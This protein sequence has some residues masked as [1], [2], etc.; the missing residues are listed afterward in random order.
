MRDFK[1]L[2]NGNLVDGAKTLDVINPATEEVFSSAPR[3]DRAQLEEAVSAAKNAFPSWSRST[4][5]E[6]GTLLLQLADVIEKHKDEFVKTLTLEQ[7]KTL[8]ESAFEFSLALQHLRYVASLD[9]PVKIIKEDRNQK[10]I[11]KNSPLGVIAIITAWNIPLYLLVIKSAPALL[12]GNT[13]VIKPAPSTPLTSLKFS[14]LCAD[15]FPAGVV[16]TVVDNN[17]LG[18]LLTS[19]PDVAK[20]SFT[21]S[22]ETGKKIMKSV[23]GTLKR[24]TLEL[25]GNDAAIVLNDVDPKEIAPKIF[26]N[27][28]IFSG[29]GC[30]AI[31]RVYVHQSQ[32][33]E[34]CHELGM[35]A[36]NVVVGDGTKAGTEMGP[37]QNKAQFDR[38]KTF[39]EDA[40]RDGN[41]V[42]G[43]NTPHPKGYFIQPTIVRDIDDTSRLV[44][45][46][47]FGPILPVL[48]YTEIDDAIERINNSPYGLGGSVWSKNIDH[49][50]EVASRINSGTVW[51]NKH[52]D[53]QSDI[54]LRGAKQSGIGTELAQE[55][56]EEFT[57]STIINIAL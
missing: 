24:L 4:I 2:I 38:V 32:Y 39:L 47:Q 27:A 9:L 37:L 50:V 34:F 12:A 5:K 33:D 49:A 54:P 14:E 15:I 1:L 35:L 55:G 3:S 8:Y 11:Q 23:S 48:S 17:D 30:L 7:G 42:A 44:R 26:A 45:E 22:T 28:T 36:T 43:G 41:I 52:L 20:I 25:G 57:Q 18:E 13:I 31:K 46:E 16:N 51:V 56:L 53:V 19:H 21:G 6:R 10:V 40:K 29:Q